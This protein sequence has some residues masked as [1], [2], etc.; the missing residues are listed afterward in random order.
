M[1]WPLPLRTCVPMCV[2]SL[3][4]WLPPPAGAGPD[5]HPKPWGGSSASAPRRETE[6]QWL[7]P[8]YNNEQT[9]ANQTQA[10][11]Q[12][13]STEAQAEEKP[14]RGTE[15]NRSQAH[16]CETRGRQGE[17]RGEDGTRR[18]RRPASP[19]SPG[20]AAAAQRRHQAL[21][22]GLLQAPAAGACCRRRRASSAASS[23]VCCCC[24]I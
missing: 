10:G 11:R 7:G 22:L 13:P 1:E 19:A 20:A 3:N 6:L 16:F 24:C 5:V 21:G 9:R 15:E 23:A 14:E 18:H 17:E 8:P 2:G 4:T 12:N